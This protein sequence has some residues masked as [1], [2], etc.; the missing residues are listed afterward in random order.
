M[1]IFGVDG[2]KQTPIKVLGRNKYST[3]NAPAAET[4]EK[5]PSYVMI[6]S[7]GSYAFSYD[8]G[9]ATVGNGT[10][11]YQTASVVSRGGTESGITPFRLDINPVAW[12]RI[13]QAG[14]VGE[15]TFVYVR[16]M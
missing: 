4:V 15:I 6:N 11:N 9:S 8:S 14:S 12:R 2:K 10:H 5:R 16:V 3:A 13:D 7:T 1:A